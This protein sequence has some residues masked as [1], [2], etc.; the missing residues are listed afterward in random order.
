MTPPPTWVLLRGLTR[1]SSHWANLPTQLRQ[2]F[3][4]ARFVLLDLPGN[5]ALH[6][7][8]SATR[9]E[10]MVDACRAQLRTE[11]IAPPYGLIGVSL[12]AMVAIDWAVRAPHEIAAAVAINTSL[13]PFNRWHQRLRPSAWGGL[14]RA[15]L[16]PMSDGARERL[17]LRL[18]SRHA[19]AAAG[20]LDAWAALRATQPV[21]RANALRQL[22][23]AARYRALPNAPEPPLLVLSAACDGFVDPA[24]SAALAAA[25]RVPI[26]IHPSAGH[27]LPLDDGPWVVERIARWL[28]GA[29]AP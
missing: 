18:T 28:A 24:C 15:G 10:A 29:P 2:R 9:I 20:V 7:Q 23:A 13:R 1:G 19:A 4:G 22:V 11:H 5:G 26:A 14:L 25:W 17:I 16:L 27:D 6:A 12:G 21:S 8:C 3:P